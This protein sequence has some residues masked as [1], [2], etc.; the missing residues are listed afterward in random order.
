MVGNLDVMRVVRAWAF[1]A[2]IELD[3]GGGQTIEGLKEG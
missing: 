2:D 1:R 3:S